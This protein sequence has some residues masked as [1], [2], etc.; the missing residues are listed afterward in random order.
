[1]GGQE[2]DGEWP[3]EE[4]LFPNETPVYRPFEQ[5]LSRELEGSRNVAAWVDREEWKADQDLKGVSLLS[6][7]Q[8]ESSAHLKLP[9]NHGLSQR[10][11]P[12]HSLPEH[13]TNGRQSQ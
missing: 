13:H 10:P 5:E 1:M 8:E 12:P 2:G 7:Q 9:H 11:I 4:C 6:K 3:G